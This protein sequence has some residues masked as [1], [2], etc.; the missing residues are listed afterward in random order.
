M[1]VFSPPFVCVWSFIFS[2][3]YGMYVLII[4][5]DLGYGQLSVLDVSLSVL[6]GITQNCEIALCALMS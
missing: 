6:L 5:F 4:T 3:M 1:Y 2:I